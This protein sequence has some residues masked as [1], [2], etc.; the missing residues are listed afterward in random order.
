MGMMDGRIAGR[1]FS[2]VPFPVPGNGE[3]AT[4]NHFLHNIGDS[5]EREYNWLA[6][7]FNGETYNGGSAEIKQRL[8]DIR[9]AL[10]S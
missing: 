3:K 2:I 10:A 4:R 5:Y 7:L 8:A 6:V 1:M 9:G